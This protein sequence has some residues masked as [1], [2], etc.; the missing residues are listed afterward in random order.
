M[1]IT[2]L[3]R[4]FLYDALAWECIKRGPLEKNGGSLLSRRFIGDGNFLRLFAFFFDRLFGDL[5]ERERKKCEHIL[6][7]AGRTRAQARLRRLRYEAPARLER[8]TR[9]VD[10]EHIALVLQVFCR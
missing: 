6:L 2:H 1:E 8:M 5:V 7:L 10:A 3:D 9:N 4:S